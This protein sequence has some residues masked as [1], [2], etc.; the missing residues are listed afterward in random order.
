[1]QNYQVLSFNVRI[2][3]ANDGIHAWDFRK[4]KVI[5]YIES[6][7]FDF[8]GLQEV[9]PGMYQELINDIKNYEFFGT[10][11][12]MDNEAVPILVKKDKYKVIESKTFWLSDTPTVESRVPGSLFSRIMTYVVLEDHEQKRI[13][14]FNTHLDYV[15]ED[16]CENQAKILSKMID[17]ITVKYQSP[18]ILVGDFNQNPDSKA[19]N[20]LTSKYKNIYEKK[21][22]IGLTFHNFSNETKGLPIDYYFYS[23]QLKVIAFEIVHHQDQNFFLSDHYPL[24]AHFSI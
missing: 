10:G 23:K 20:Y 1:M 9:G 13:S 5:A 8:I 12:G 17:E 16:V 11:R 2:N 3:V 7:D 6:S 24:I 14:F 19:I 21:D 18:F 22:R 15:S 4:D